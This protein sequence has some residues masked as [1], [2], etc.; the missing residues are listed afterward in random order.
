L[1]PKE[2]PTDKDQGSTKKEKWAESQDGKTPTSEN[3]DE[4][5]ILIA[6]LHAR[7]TFFCLAIESFTQVS[8]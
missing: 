6:W 1:L 8:T 2:K 4:I 7:F 3:S 5:K